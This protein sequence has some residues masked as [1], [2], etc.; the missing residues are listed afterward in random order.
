MKAGLQPLDAGIIAN[1]KALY[2][3]RMLEWLVWTI[4]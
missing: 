3:R 4:D 2:Q 1:F